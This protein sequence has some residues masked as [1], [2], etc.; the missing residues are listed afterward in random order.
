MPNI[1]KYVHERS[2]LAKSILEGLPVPV[3]L[4]DTKCELVFTNGAFNTWFVRKQETL[5]SLDTTYDLI[6]S[7]LSN[8]LAQI[9]KNTLSQSNVDNVKQINIRTHIQEHLVCKVSF[10]TVSME[11]DVEGVMAVV[12]DRPDVSD[13][14]EMYKK[15]ANLDQLTGIANRFG[16][17]DDYKSLNAITEGD[18]LF[19]VAIIDIDDLK[20]INDSQGHLFG[21]KYIKNTANGLNRFL[22]EGDILARGGGDEFI[23]VVLDVFSINHA[24]KLVERLIFD[25]QKYCQVLGTPVKLSVGTALWKNNGLTLDDLIGCADN[26]MYEAKQRNKKKS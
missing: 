19:A 9:L 20:L 5:Q 26:R 8:E 15:Q 2:S 16:F 23:V 7:L 11:G 24:E 1:A 13:V 18:F 17:Y 3:A 21:D 6:N 14:V 22:R 10:T 4:F 12:E 25:V